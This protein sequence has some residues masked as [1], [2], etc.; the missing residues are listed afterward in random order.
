MGQT[1]RD[2]R[3]SRLGLQAHEFHLLLAQLIERFAQAG[4]AF[5]NHAFELL[6]QVFE[7]GIASGQFACEL[8]VVPSQQ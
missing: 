1:A 4:G 3:H 6:I 8:A 5:L 7:R 2:L